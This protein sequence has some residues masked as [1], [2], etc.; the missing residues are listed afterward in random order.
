MDRYVRVDRRNTEQVAI[1]ENE[2]SAFGLLA[3]AVIL[4]VIE[5]EVE[6]P[7]CADSDNGRGQDAQLYNLRHNAAHRASLFEEI[8]AKVSRLTS[9][10]Y[11]QDKGHS[12]IVLRA[13][14]R[15]INKAVTIGA[16][17]FVLL[18]ATLRGKFEPSL[19]APQPK[20]SSA[21]LWA[22][23]KTL[24]LGRWTS[25]TH[26]NRWR[27]ASIAWRPPAMCRC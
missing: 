10:L 13:M 21:A 3:A 8:P 5:V 6:H 19:T 12:S 26:G 18:D 4:Q 14:G 27:R 20:L 7:V 17:L 9:W 15:A 24:R 23:T 2:A 16:V 25:R 22:F 11:L 1:Q